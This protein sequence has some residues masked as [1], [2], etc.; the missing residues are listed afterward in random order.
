MPRRKLSPRSAKAASTRSQAR[1]RQRVLQNSYQG[2]ETG[3]FH[4][5]LVDDAPSA[6]TSSQIPPA[7]GLHR[8]PTPVESQAAGQPVENEQEMQ[9]HDVFAFDESEFPDQPASPAINPGQESRPIQSIEDELYEF[10]EDDFPDRG[11]SPVIS[12]NSRG[13]KTGS[14]DSSAHL[15]TQSHVSAWPNTPSAGSRRSSVSSEEYPQP[16]PWRTRNIITSATVTPEPEYDP[17]EMDFELEAENQLREEH[18]QSQSL[19]GS[20]GDQSPEVNEDDEGPNLLLELGLHLLEFKGCPPGTHQRGHCT[21]HH[22][23]HRTL[24]EIIT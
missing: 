22:E 23:N 10:H 3:S 19:S 1:W 4:V 8:T 13:G 11:A 16:R 18:L 5:Q 24:E 6:S 21:Q 20:H 7:H 9:D 15:S 17:D 14:K 2:R 12:R